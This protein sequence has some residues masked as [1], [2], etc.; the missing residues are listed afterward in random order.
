MLTRLEVDGFKNLLGFSSDFGPYTCI[1]GPNSVGKS[2]IFDAIVFL[3]LLADRTFVEAAAMVRSTDGGPA[4]PGMLFFDDGNNGPRR[5]RLA[6]E[7]I[8]P[9]DVTDDFGRQ[10]SA[11]TTWLRY[12]LVL[13]Y[14]PAAQT[15]PLGRS[16]T[17]RLLEEN[18]E[19]MRAGQAVQRM[20]WT[21]G[22]KSFRDTA[23]Y[24]RRRNADFISTAE[25]DS[26]DITINVHQDGGSRGQPRK[27]PAASAP[28]T[29]VSTTTT[30][31]APTI[32]AAR[33][34]MRRWHLLALEPSAMRQ[35]DEVTAPTSVSP[36]GAHLAA[37]LLR[38]GTA[39][40][41]INSRVAAAASALTDVRSIRVDFDERREL[42]T[43][44]AGI[45]A[46]PEIPARNLSDGTLR[47]LA[48][49]IMEADPE[50]DGVI[51]MEEPENGIHPARI[52]A[53][54][55]LVHDLAVDP[56]EAPGDEN[57]MRQ[58][59]VNTHSPMFVRKQDKDDLV[60]AMPTPVTR[61]G[62]AATTVRLHPMQ[63]SWRASAA[64][65]VMTKSNVVDY[66][67]TNLGD[68]LA[69]QL[70]AGGDEDDA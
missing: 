48:L 10:G 68:Q 31:D 19:S 34:E 21:R 5:M 43:L 6:A 65:T 28:R 53:M 58:V 1:A 32:L 62:R 8:V 23:I 38:M 41:D 47:F 54:V 52:Q 36:N 64:V 30:V 17:I 42:L 51:C 4:D 70:G 26:G 61:G 9:S 44:K 33:N 22:K 12:E 56:D 20:P 55:D 14:H 60:L 67:K 35:P 69:F 59:I 2:N 40:T 25:T 39:D 18:L 66:L 57:P 46:G 29:L 16:A 50:F 63:E 13:E 3:S 7:M 15:G 11:T 27:S 45:G 49:S 24:N 37:A